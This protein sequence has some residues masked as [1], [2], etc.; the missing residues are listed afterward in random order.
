MEILHLNFNKKSMNKFKLLISLLILSV[1]TSCKKDVPIKSKPNEFGKN[2]ILPSF[3]FTPFEGKVA[4]VIKDNDASFHV[5][6]AGFDQLSDIEAPN[7][8]FYYLNI[9]HLKNVDAQYCR[10]LFEKAK[11]TETPIIIDTESFIDVNYVLELILPKVDSQEVFDNNYASKSSGTDKSSQVEGLVIVPRM[12]ESV[13]VVSYDPQQSV[14]NIYLQFISKTPDDSWANPLS[15][16]LL[17]EPYLEDTSHFDSLG[18]KRG[19]PAI[20]PT[21]RHNW[22][23]FYDSRSPKPMYSL[24]NDPKV[25][26][27]GRF[28]FNRNYN[29]NIPFDDI[30]N[31]LHSD[32]TGDWHYNPN[33][34]KA[35][36][37]RQITNHKLYWDPSFLPYRRSSIRMLNSNELPS[38]TDE[39]NQPKVDF[40]DNASSTFTIGFTVQLKFPITKFLGVAEINP[41]VTVSHSWT[42][43]ET[44]AFGQKG[45]EIPRG[46]RGRMAYVTRVI[47]SAGYH[48][49][50]IQVPYLRQQPNNPRAPREY[51]T[52]N[53]YYVDYKGYEYL[54]YIPLNPKGQSAVGTKL[55]FRNLPDEPTDNDPRVWQISENY[56]EYIKSRGRLPR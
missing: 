1:F 6:T 13:D 19:R 2:A 11:K 31:R 52:R 21:R 23:P 5:V 51:Q 39:R 36:V 34:R 48:N 44:R 26:N 29:F 43:G 15:P 46:Y 14:S 9:D 4:K 3:V 35:K 28:L 20:N 16:E 24:E 7:P 12:D 40:A 41:S 22:R 37:T 54:G 17:F 45:V 38:P 27:T 47:R 18:G 49:Q 56:E 8:N 32:I 10:K 25:D 53:Y 55:W 50:L 33:V 42:K 30:P